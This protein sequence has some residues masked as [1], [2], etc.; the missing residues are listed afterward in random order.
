MDEP[1][2]S[3]V[4][5]VRD[6]MPFLPT[7][8]ASLR[9]Q[10]LTGLEILA[11]ND[12]SVDAS[13]E[14]LDTW[15]RQDP[16]VRVVHLPAVGLVT[17]LEAGLACCRAHLIARMDA[18]DVCHPRRLE[19]QLELF[20]TNPELGV[21]SSGVQFFPRSGIEEG[22]RI[23][24]AWLN[25]LRTHDEMATERFVE[26][27]VAHPSAMVRRELLERVGGYRD[28]GWPEDYDLWLRLFEAGAR[29]GKIDRPLYFWRDHADRL[30][31]RD[32]R[33]STDAFLR[34]KA[35]FLVRGPLAEARGVV[36]WGA[37][38]TGRRLSRHVADEGG[39]IDV[40]VDI[41][42]AK[43]GRSLHGRPIVAPEVLPELLGSGTVV[44]AAVASRGAR[45][46]IRQ[47]LNALGLTEAVDYWCVA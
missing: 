1:R 33:Y 39:S 2:V 42:P 15:G 24:E 11:M 22:F 3:V 9:R 4:L 5:P 6:G 37:G 46:L 21:V 13:G 7:A 25:S 16:R 34:C 19:M 18:D 28:N 36:V 12:G 38:Q 35:H 23:Y 43:I 32:A 47:R 40:F 10:T 27:P 8:V 29:F 14:V 44:L 30:T 45:D 17:A 31:R 41:D 20:D 26:S